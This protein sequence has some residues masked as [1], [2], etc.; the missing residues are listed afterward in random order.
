MNRDLR[1]ASGRTA[2]TRKN[3]GNAEVFSG[4]FRYSKETSVIP[5][6]AGLH[7]QTLYET[8]FRANLEADAPVDVSSQAATAD[9]IEQHPLRR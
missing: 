6:A 2:L 4:H 1:R 7:R 3:F 5:L 8:T 9:I